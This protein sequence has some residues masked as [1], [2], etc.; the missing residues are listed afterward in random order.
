MYIYIY[1]HTHIH[2]Y[3]HKYI[4]IYK[5]R[6]RERESERETKTERERESAGEREILSQYLSVLVFLSLCRTR[7]LS[8]FL[9]RSLP[10]LLIFPLFFSLPLS[11]PP[12]L[13]ISVSLYV[14]ML[15]MQNLLDMLLHTY[16]HTCTT[17]THIHAHTYLYVYVYILTFIVSIY[18]HTY[19]YTH[20]YVYIYID[21]SVHLCTIYLK[22]LFNLY[23]HDVCMYV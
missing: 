5:H 20:K 22:I 11:P 14:D 1:V 3:I 2:I 6:E 7:T 12:L 16:L 19:T 23:P 21:I 17:Y 18:P 9:E 13:C 10:V 4:N 15:Y 8:L